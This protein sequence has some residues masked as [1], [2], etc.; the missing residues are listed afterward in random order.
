MIPTRLV[1]PVLAAALAFLWAERLPA[2]D[3]RDLDPS[4][5]AE[6]SVSAT[7]LTPVAELTSSPAFTTEV[8]TAIGATGTVTYWF[9]RHLGV[10]AQGTWAPAELNVRP[11]EFTG[12][13]PRGLGDVEYLAGTGA[14]AYRLVL[15]APLAA[16]EPYFGLGGGARHLSVEPQASPD[17]EDATDPVGTV[18]AGASTRVGGSVA[19]RLELRD[20]VSRYESPLDGRT[21]L[22]NDILVSV[23]VAVRP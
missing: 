17:A 12:P 4:R 9:T 22:Q 7:I 5:G 21:R 14:V 13:I 15:P 10:M 11:S 3:T 23:G 20:L 1:G 16:L 19:L 18:I 2:Q 8:S 6:L